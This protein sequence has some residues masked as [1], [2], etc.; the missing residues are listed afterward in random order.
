M[1]GRAPEI[2]AGLRDARQ[3]NFPGRGLHGIV[4][5]SKNHSGSRSK[6]E[7]EVAALF[8]SLIESAELRG[9]EPKALP[10]PGDARR[11]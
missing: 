11:P 10:A 3:A 8:Y 9:V 4:V 7:T 6:R 1:L 2:G 5:G